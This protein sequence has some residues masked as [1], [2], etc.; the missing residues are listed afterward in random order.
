MNIFSMKQRAF[1]FLPVVAAVLATFGMSSASAQTFAS[2]DAGSYSN[3]GTGSTGGTGFQ[4]W[5]MY[6]TGGAGGTTGYAGTF[7]GNGGQNIDSTNG[8]YWGMY[9]NQ[10]QTAA[11]E[12][13]RAFSNSLPVNATFTI[14]WQNHGIG[15]NYYDVGGFNLR[16]GDNTNLMTASSYIVDGSLFSFFYA[17]GGSDNYEV[18]DGNGINPIPVNFADGSAG[19]Q[20]QV[21]LLPNNRYNLV[22][23]NATGTQVYWAT[24]SQPLVG[25]GTIDSVALYDFDTGQTGDQDFNNMEIYYAPPEVINL[26]P[27]NGTVYA[28]TSSP[29]SFAV[30]SA[31]STI[32]SNKIQFTLNGV[33]QTG[34]NW[35]V[36]GSGTAS[37][38]V[39]LN[40]PLQGNQ[41]Y[42][43]TIIATDAVGNSSTNTFSFNT[44]LPSYNNIYIEASDYNYGGGQYINNALYLNGSTPQPAGS[45]VQP[46]QDYAL[47]GG[48]AEQGIDYFINTNTDTGANNVYRSG[49]LAGVENATDIDHN[50][51]A[52]NGFQPYDLDYNES[53]QWEDYTRELSNNVTYAVYARMAAFGANPT[54][55]LERMAAPAVSSVSQPGA[56]LGTFVAPQTGG[57]QT[58][59]F[60]PLHDFF[61][62]PVLIN[63][64]GTNTFRITDIGGN[65]AYNVGYLLLVAVTNQVPLGPYVTSG[66]PYPGAT[67]ANPGGSISFTIANRTTSVV[68]ASIQLFVNGTNVTSQL[69]FSN[70]VAGTVVTY[71]PALT[72]FLMAGLNTAQVIFGDGSVLQ[73]DTWQFTVE[74]YS[75]LPTAW[76]MP[77]T[78][79]YSPGFYEQ[80]AK[81][82]DS[83]TNT[84]FP[85]NLAR[86]VAQLAGTLTNSQTGQ[87]YANE[88][89]NG[90][91]CV[92]PNTINYAIDPSFDGLFSPT[93]PFPDIVAGTTNNVA[94]AADMYV[95]LAPGLY[96]FSVYSDDGFQFSAGSSPAATNMILGIA[97]YGRGPA[98]TQFTFLVQAAGLYPMQL[99]YFKSQLGGGGVELYDNSASG[100]VLLN[101]P[102]TTGSIKVYYITPAPEL[103]I[104]R[105]GNNVVLSWTGAGYVLQSAS[106]VN[107]PYTTISGATSPYTVPASARQ[108]FFRLAP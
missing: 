6:N 19:L 27:A 55:S 74:S 94:M 24:N 36:I 100:N 103:S 64:G 66:Y 59:T 48:E 65:G 22:V 75:I 4:P 108:Q 89:L 1:L 39:V 102:N 41:V 7:R 52:N 83:A 78:G 2:D 47:V 90:G 106:A 3:W 72:N 23:E 31:A 91:V 92:E 81:G 51:F 37:N 30:M 40:A 20:V 69:A 13:F 95:Q 71:Q 67:G 70:N 54:M 99:I 34:A 28:P 15:F 56:V 57:T 25:S 68:P 49:D 38:Q 62:N 98:S 107:G 85:P 96:N 17:G 14:L 73:T 5:V 93:N 97:D 46:N 35:T 45:Y 16:N 88:A 12:A 8:N 84:D 32:S 60:V 26:T 44:W 87:P 18:Y 104:T 101:D 29:L 77:L 61:S 86:A 76:A 10:A 9:A 53:G 11:S 43:G 63:F 79:S 82:D 58:Y 80:I 21:T 42:N 33:L 105:S 50:N